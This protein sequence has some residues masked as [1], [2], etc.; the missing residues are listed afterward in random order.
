MPTK[1]TNYDKLVGCVHNWAGAKKQENYKQEL[2]HL[3]G[4]P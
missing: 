3:F 1:Y 4:P 2:E